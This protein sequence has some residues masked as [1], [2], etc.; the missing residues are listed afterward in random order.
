MSPRRLPHVAVI[1][2]GFAGLKT[3]VDL[4]DA[5]IQVSLIES[6]PTLGG[7]A[8]SFQ[9]PET[10][11][12]VDNGQHLFLSGYTHTLDFLKRLGTDQQLIFQEDLKVTFVTPSGKSRTLHCP[13]LKNPWHLLVGLMS[14]SGLSLFD[15][16]NLFRM[17]WEVETVAQTQGAETVEVW[18]KRLGQSEK[19]RENFWYPLAIATLNEDPKIASAMGLL[20][21]LRTLMGEP[22]E[23]ARLGMPSVGLSELYTQ[24]ASKIIEESGGQILLNQTVTEIEVR[25]WMVSGLRLADG[26]TLESDV[27]VSAL[28]PAA[29]HK[30]FPANS[31]GGGG[32]LGALARY[33]SSPIVSVN[34]WLD[35][36]ITQDLFVGMVGTRFQWLFNKPALLA[37]TGA[38]ANYLAMIL[39]AAHDYI[40][41]PNEQLV[42]MA[43]EDL[44][45]CFPK[46]QEAKLIR[47][48][49]VRE[50]DATVSLTPECEK[51]R[52]GV[53]SKLE[54][55]LV[56]GDWVATGL[57][58]TIE[59]AVL[60]GAMCAR[61]ALKWLASVPSDRYNM[62]I[63]HEA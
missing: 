15:K 25:D 23:S 54:N 48:Q 36:A 7:R 51:I 40:D 55:F 50:R 38:Q 42:Q 59:S 28:P 58:A 32:A 63:T 6:K 20:S 24:A 41:Q 35:Q 53:V 60:S 10:G 16:L 18:L 37:S 22:W 21:V 30:I 45:A 11:D 47:S 61:E 33:H 2:G 31:V 1:G 13:R 17:V 46:A 26:S 56:A 9:D 57:P 29:L 12:V 19:A 34:H 52:P 49:V 44:K 4:A 62:P 8:R 5:G 43:L 3:A 27:V 39:S 14:F